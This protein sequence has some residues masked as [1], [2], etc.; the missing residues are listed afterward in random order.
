MVAPYEAPQHSLNEPPVAP[1]YALS[2]GQ[3][4]WQRA[5]YDD[6]TGEELPAHLVR[7]ARADEIKFMQG[8]H[9][10]DVVPIAECKAVT[11]KAS[12]W[13]GG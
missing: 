6:L 4:G 3:L 13:V 2:G 8:W 11:G 10:W 7:A 1:P 9:V 12:I 5:V